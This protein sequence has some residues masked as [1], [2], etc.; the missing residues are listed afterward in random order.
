MKNN[1]E[2]ETWQ[3]VVYNFLISHFTNLFQ[4]PFG[5]KG[6]N[7]SNQC[8]AFMGLIGC[9]RGIKHHATYLSALMVED[10]FRFNQSPIKL[11]QFKN[12]TNR[13]PYEKPSINCMIIT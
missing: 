7:F 4:E 10:T 5:G 2:L 1:I 6:K 3:R 13:I 11:N 8:W 12:L 9:L